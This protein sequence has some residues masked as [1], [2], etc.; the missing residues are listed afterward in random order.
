MAQMCLFFQRG[1]RPG[2]LAPATRGHPIGSQVTP[3]ISALVPRLPQPPEATQ[4]QSIKAR[5]CC[6]KIPSPFVSV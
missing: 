6:V 3:A 1:L 5:S 4:P 2:S